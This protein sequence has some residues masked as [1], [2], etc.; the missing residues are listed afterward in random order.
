MIL[1]RQARLRLGAPLAVF[2]LAV[3]AVLVSVML[4]AISLL[5]DVASAQE[6]PFSATQ[7]S[8]R[9]AGAPHRPRNPVA[10]KTNAIE[11]PNA[12]KQADVNPPPQLEPFSRQAN[13]QID[14]PE[15][16]LPN[17]VEAPLRSSQQSAPNEDLPAPPQSSSQQS[18]QVRSRP[19]QTSKQMLLEDA[20]GLIT[21]VAQ[22]MALIEVLHELSEKRKLS[23]VHASDIKE[24]VSISL[25]GVKVD[26][27]L[28]ALLSATGYTW[29]ENRGI[30]YITSLNNKTSRSAPEVT[31]RLVRVFPLDFASAE[32]VD[33]AI[34]GVLSPV[35]SSYT[36]IS[37][38]LDTRK[39]GE[40]IVVEDL[41]GSIARIEQYI[42]QV[43]IPPRQVLIEAHV[44]EV[45]LTETQ[46]NGIN[47]EH[48]AKVHNHQ[49]KLGTLG[50]KP[51]GA[52]TFVAE[53]SS[54]SLNGLIDALKTTSNAKTLAQPKI[55]ALN[56]QQAHLQVGQQLGF[57]ITSQN[58]NV[59]IQ[60]VRFLEVGIVLQVTPRISRDG[61][62]MM[63]VKPKVSSGLVNAETK[64]PEEK[65][66]E[67]ET[68]VML[69]NGMGMVIG[70]L[71]Q[72]KDVTNISQVPRLGDLKILGHLFKNR[73][74][75]KERSEII[76]VLIPRIVESSEVLPEQDQ[77]DCIRATEQEQL[78]IIRAKTP[79]F[80]Q[81]LQ[82][83]QSSG[84]YDLGQTH[85]PQQDP[86]RGQVFNQQGG[87]QQARFAARG[88]T[89]N[90]STQPSAPRVATLPPSSPQRTRR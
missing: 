21:L 4:G 12:T 61:R 19:E 54:D 68:S 9:N 3:R 62:I 10:K 77:Y 40:S 88:T 29:T 74:V 78:D 71:I 47:F 56:G 60:D 43:D 39:T 75:E 27:A 80:D 83:N 22:D 33:K 72:E 82:P 52:S 5:I 42:Q 84:Q 15:K 23:F 7:S 48:I 46:K 51:A 28:T 50:V 64:L 87:I 37:D 38:P 89:Q 85:A 63:S 31:G 36:M 44:L 90:N 73:Q 13:F 18:I 49:I 16:V 8:R 34:K 45:R 30:I 20:N 26:D 41:A 25:R 66:S 69:S 17:A 55:L 32:E 86:Q 65:T 59:T 1:I 57:P 35:G 70:G 2:S 53:I 6:A 81:H 24:R 14:E 76:F 79:L 58:Q 67:V 11:S